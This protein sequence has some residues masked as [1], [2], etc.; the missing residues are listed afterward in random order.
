[1]SEVKGYDGEFKDIII[2]IPT[3]TIEMDINVKVYKNGEIVKA[4]QTLDLE[5]V[6]EAENTFHMCCY[7]E[8]PVYELTE[9]GIEYLKGLME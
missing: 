3:N 5:G 8:Y 2:S 9:K 6:K 4:V 1:M 7:G